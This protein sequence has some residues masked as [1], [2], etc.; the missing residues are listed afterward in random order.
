MR[1][2]KT[3]HPGKAALLPTIALTF[4]ALAAP[5]VQSQTYS[6][7]YNFTGH[8][9]GQYPNGDLIQDAGGNLYG[10]TSNGGSGYQGTVFEVDPAGTESVLYSFP[11]E[12]PEGAQPLAGLFR[13]PEGNLFGTT[14]VGD[15]PP[16][17]TIFELNTSNEPTVLH[18]FQ[19]TT[20]GLSPTSRMVSINGVLYGTAAG[21]TGTACGG[22]CG[23]IYRVTKSGK[24]KVMYQFTGGSDGALGPAPNGLIRDAAGN[25]YGT[26]FSGGKG[27]ASAGH[28]TVFKLDTAGVLTVLYSFTGKTDGDRP[29]GRLIRDVNGNIHGATS[30]GGDPTCHC[31]VVYHIDAAGNFSVLHTFHGD[32]FP[33]GGLLDVS[34]ALYGLAQLGSGVMYRIGNTGNYSVVYTFTGGTDG[35]NPQGELALGT[36]GSLYGVTKIGG[37]GCSNCGVVFKYMP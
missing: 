27:G 31:G 1:N 23:V 33:I 34:G 4:L 15:C 10:T 12:G 2:V 8:P 16:C 24:Y 37:S 26:A 35:G 6:V 28:G 21:G 20:D 29:I 9:D 17:G 11:L 25:L 30:G 5:L 36:D 14:S 7:L 22:G 19:N 3:R 18:S 32:T 13:D